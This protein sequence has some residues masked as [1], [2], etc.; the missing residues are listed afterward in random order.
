MFCISDFI[1]F[2]EIAEKTCTEHHDSNSSLLNS[3]FDVHHITHMYIYRH[4]ITSTILYRIIR[5]Y[6]QNKLHIK[7]LSQLTII[8]TEL[9]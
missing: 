4:K 1:P 2:D 6:I 3:H 9:F 5:D 7:F 8:L